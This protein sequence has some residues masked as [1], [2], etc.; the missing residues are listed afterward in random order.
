MRSKSK[1]VLEGAR[2]ACESDPVQEIRPTHLAMNSHARMD[3]SNAR[4]LEPSHAGRSLGS[5]LLF[6]VVAWLIAALKTTTRNW[7]QPESLPGLERP[8]YTKV[9]LLPSKAGS[10]FL[11]VAS[12]A[13][14]VVTGSSTLDLV[15]V[16][17]KPLLLEFGVLVVLQS[18]GLPVLSK[19]VMGARKIRWAG[20]GHRGIR[21]SSSLAKGLRV[22]A[23]ATSRV[24]KQLVTG[25]SRTSASK[26]VNRSK[27]II[28][29][30]Y[31]PN[32]S[33]EAA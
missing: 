33:N 1:A 13:V 14:M 10:S 31:H 30:F 9:E 3:R 2:A 29:L 20:V 17:L 15:M 6:F 5:F 11:S 24:W 12:G 32:D 18:V 16:A 27:K 19:L 7:N 22:A 8:A 26:I 25:Y 4:K 21:V 28:K 23:Q